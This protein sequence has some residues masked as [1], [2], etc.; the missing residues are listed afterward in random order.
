MN[1]VDISESVAIKPLPLNFC[2][3]VREMRALE[4]VVSA[5]VADEVKEFLLRDIWAEKIDD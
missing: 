1:K 2:V 3:A 4:V 5:D